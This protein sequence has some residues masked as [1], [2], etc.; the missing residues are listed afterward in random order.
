M[1]AGSEV[2]SNFNPSKVAVKR[3]RAAQRFWVG[4][5]LALDEEM[6]QDFAKDKRAKMLEAIIKQR[7]PRC[8]D[9]PPGH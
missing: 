6:D 4:S 7:R 1:T 9:K 3:I 2:T 8:A 5:E